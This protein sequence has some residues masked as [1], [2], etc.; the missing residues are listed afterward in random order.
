MLYE[1]LSM[2]E[3][4]DSTWQKQIKTL[5]FLNEEDEFPLLDHVIYKHQSEYKELQESLKPNSDYI[6]KKRWENM[7]LYQKNKVTE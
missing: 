5:N 1:V 2:E 6:I 3:M 4:S 7:I